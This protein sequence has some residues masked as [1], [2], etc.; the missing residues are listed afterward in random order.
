M[1]GCMC[2]S[3]HGVH[4]K[5]LLQVSRSKK[6]RYEELHVLARHPEHLFTVLFLGLYSPSRQT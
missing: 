2:C 3:A 6:N 4:Y 5:M 1:V